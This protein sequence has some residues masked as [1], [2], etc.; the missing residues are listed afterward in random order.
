MIDGSLLHL[1]MSHSVAIF[2]GYLDLTNLFSSLN[3]LIH[4]HNWTE[5]AQVQGQFSQDVV[6]DMAKGWNNFI[7]TG[8]WATLLIGLF[9]GYMF[10][11]FTSSG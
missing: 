6:G 5:I 11:V 1:N 10:R 7:R 8:Q 9:L 3:D 4:V 2:F